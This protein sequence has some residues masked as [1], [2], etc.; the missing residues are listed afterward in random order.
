[1]QATKDG[2]ELYT[3]T[4]EGELIR[5]YT[6]NKGDRLRLIRAESVAPP[7]PDNLVPVPKEETGAFTMNRLADARKLFETLTAHEAHFILWACLYTAYRSCCVVYGRQTD[8]TAVELAEIFG[9]ERRTVK[10]ILASLKEKNAI[11]VEKTAGYRF[12]VYLNP[13]ICCR[14][15]DFDRD[16]LSRFEKGE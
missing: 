7:P 9:I 3:L 6:L 11:A 4:D 14:G 2:T 8:Y 15:T 5:E 13:R 10:K 12:S 1:M 16:A